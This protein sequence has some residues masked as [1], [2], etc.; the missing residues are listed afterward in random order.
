MLRGLRD[1]LL[2][3][4]AASEL[5]QRQPGGGS[6]FAGGQMQLAGQDR[7]QRGD[8]VPAVAVFPHEGRRAI[9]TMHLVPFQV[10]DQ[11]FLVELANRQ[12]VFDGKGFH[13]ILGVMR[14]SFGSGGRHPP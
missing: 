4:M 12:L 2:K 1:S 5:L 3:Q 14:L 9:Q 6:R 13:G 10:V 11:G 7:R 8:I